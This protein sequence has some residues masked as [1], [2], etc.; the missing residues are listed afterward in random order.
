MDYEVRGGR[1]GTWAL[2]L[3]VVDHCNLRCEQCCS[4]SPHLATWFADPRQLEAD[5][6]R[7][8]RV[9]RPSV[10][11]LTGGEP[12]LHPRLAEIAAIARRSGVSERL[13]M[14][15]NGI[16]IRDVP[17]SVWRDLDRMTLSFYT[18]APLPEA[19]LAYIEAQCERFEVTL[20]TKPS[21]SFQQITPETPW[22][23]VEAA[24]DVHDACWMRSRCHL[25]RDGVFFTCT[26]PPHLQDYLASRGEPVALVQHD[27]VPLDGADLGARI[28]AYLSASD[29]LRSCQH[30]LGGAGTSIPHRQLPAT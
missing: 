6:A 22:P 2:E 28:L 7:V 10:L 1:I 16:R 12:T 19:T 8:A 21:A 3:H 11:K 18:S 30:C 20:T 25:L 17:E 15:T 23:S 14:T 4:L 5:L 9:L 27:G 13:S 29:P 26:R 24:R